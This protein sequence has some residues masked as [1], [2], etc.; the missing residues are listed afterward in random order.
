MA[1]DPRALILA[2]LV[3]AV[4]WVV[5]YRI[6]NMYSRLPPEPQRKEPDVDLFPGSHEEGIKYG[7]GSY[8]DEFLSAIKIFG[9]LERPVFHELTRSMQTRKLIAGETLNL[10]E[11]KGFCIVVDGQV[12][13]FVKSGQRT[14]VADIFS[15]PHYDSPSEDGRGVGPGHQRYQLLTEIRNG[16]PMSSLFSIMSLFTEDVNVRPPDDDSTA[17][18]PDGSNLPRRPGMHTSDSTVSF[19]DLGGGK[20]GTPTS[21]DGPSHDAG[22]QSP[23]HAS[24]YASKIPPISLDNRQGHRPSRPTLDRRPT[25]TSA[26]PDVLARATVDTTIAIIPASAFRRLIKTYPKATAQIVHLILTR[27]QRVTLAT[28]YDYLGLTEEVLHTEKSIIRFTS[29]QLPNPLRGEPLNRLKEKFKRERERIGED[30]QDKGI[31]LHNAAANQNRTSV[32]AGD[33]RKGAVLQSMAMQRPLSQGGSNIYAAREGRSAHSPSPGDLLANI[34]LARTGG[35]RLS[36]ATDYLPP[37]ATEGLR[38]DSKSPLQQRIFDP[39]DANTYSRRSFVHGRDSADEDDVFRVSV[40]ECMFKAMGFGAVGGSLRESESAQESPHLASF[41]HPRHRNMTFN[42]SGDGGSNAFGFFGSTMDESVDGDTESM[43]ST[44]AAAGVQPS[45][46]SLALDVRNDVEI[47]F[48]PKGSILIEHGERNPGLYYV[49]DGFLDMCTSD[50]GSSVDSSESERRSFHKS[51]VEDKGRTGRSRSADG[52]HRIRR[53]V[54]L[55]KPGG[56]AGYIGSVSSYRSFIDVVAKTDV[57][58]GFLPRAPLERIVDKYPIALLT[59]AKRLTDLLPRLIL[60]ID[61]ALEWVQVNASEV[62]FNKDDDSEAI[63]IVLN[64]R[65]RLVNDKKDGGIKVMDEFGQGE[66]IGELEVLTESSRPGTLHAIRDTELVKFPRTLF[67][68]L[69]QE[70]PNIT[71]KISKIIAS[72]MRSL[73]DDPSKLM[74]KDG[75]LMSNMSFKGSSNVNLRTVAILPVTSGVP[76]VEF[77]ARLM[78][79]LAQV[80][81]PNGAT[82]LNQT[83]ILNHLG[84]HAFNKMGK[85][86]LSQ[87]LADLEE[88]YSLVLYVAGKSIT[89]HVCFSCIKAHSLTRA[90]TRVS[91]LRG[92]RRASPRQIASSW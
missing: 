5:R 83:A 71:I 36:T 11:E 53:S 51:P 4:A 19:P 49:I 44:S 45:A 3:A 57:Y 66:S 59:M 22:A 56:L 75:G 18:A 55:I 14:P 81:P 91:T 79:A 80:G 20:S 16:A 24:M 27:F 25:S 33:L 72:R 29:C 84:R 86:K 62:L 68:S 8:L 89:S 70:H 48:F 64:G 65:L 30:E 46:H 52:R 32:N 92:R 9:Y 38:R 40:L 15:D 78:A 43:T 42:S 39:F 28:A 73:F 7:L 6:L 23:M 21:P 41:D 60:H 34:Q 13:I 76:V 90:Q 50:D 31:A 12:D 85:L 77:G 69:A 58:V 47:V 1:S 26:H 37:P 87:Y 88:K 35:R 74:A 54:A 10:E 63:Y 2:A 67:N 17:P 82:S 61:F